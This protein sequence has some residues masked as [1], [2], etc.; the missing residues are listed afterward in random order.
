[1]IVA[2]HIKES[3][4]IHFYNLLFFPEFAHSYVFSIISK[5]ETIIIYLGICVCY[6]YFLV[7]EDALSICIQITL[8]FIDTYRQKKVLRI[9]NFEWFALT[10][11]PEKITFCDEF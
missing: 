8:T 3:H 11:T 5:L 4:I 6:N 7:P 2:D 9:P 1:M 10:E